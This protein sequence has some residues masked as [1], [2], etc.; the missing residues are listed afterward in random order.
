[1]FKD[2]EDIN[3]WLQKR[4]REIKSD[5][6]AFD[7]FDSGENSIKNSAPP[8]LPP[9][10]ADDDATS[11]KA[12]HAENDTFQAPPTPEDK[13]GGCVDIRAAVLSDL[14]TIG[15]GYGAGAD[16]GES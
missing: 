12:P 15:G 3:T 14:A 1:M 11:E 9:S 4:E 13:V 7:A 2:A 16:A 8:A 10:A 6:E 5:L